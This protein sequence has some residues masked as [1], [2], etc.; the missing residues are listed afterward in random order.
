MISFTNIFE[1]VS[2]SRSEVIVIGNSYSDVIV[3][4]IPSGVT[5]SI[6]HGC[7]NI[8]YISKIS[9]ILYLIKKDFSS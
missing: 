4:C 7:T 9:F 2:G 6:L 8:P 5:Y 3:K 1:R